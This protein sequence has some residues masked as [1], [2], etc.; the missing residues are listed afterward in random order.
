MLLLESVQEA[1]AESGGR[2]A[3]AG[4]GAVVVAAAVLLNGGGAG[5][6][7]CAGNGHKGEDSCEDC[8]NH[9]ERSEENS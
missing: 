9:F 3:G 8:L 1:V 7:A 4:V 5:G 2:Q 6:V